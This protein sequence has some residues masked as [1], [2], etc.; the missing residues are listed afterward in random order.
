[1]RS[2]WPNGTVTQG[3]ATY[4]PA[5]GC[6]ATP[7]GTRI[8]CD[9]PSA[10]APQSAWVAVGVYSLEGGYRLPLP[11]GT[12][13]LALK[14]VRL[15][16]IQA[17]TGIPNPLRFDLGGRVRLAGYELSAR[18]VRPG[19]T[20]ELVLYWQALANMDR[21]YTVFTQLLDEEPRIWA[22]DDHQPLQGAYP[23][24]RWA[25]G[26]VIRDVYRLR[27]REDTPPGVYRLEV[28]MYLLSTGERLYRD[29]L[30]IV[31]SIRVADI[32]VEN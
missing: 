9:Y 14:A 5:P 31:N 26:D 6:P 21:D 32:R 11:D 24:S 12:D 17:D 16:P 2:S 19:D 23:T 20:L 25:P 22:Q 29:D 28:G 10:G 15:V 18:V 30:P 4:P 1:M 7:S 13:R 27:V 8:A 3:A